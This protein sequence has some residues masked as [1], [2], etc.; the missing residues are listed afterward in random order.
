MAQALETDVSTLI[1]LSLAYLSAEWTDIPMVVAEWSL[2]EEHERLDFALE[3]PIREDRLRQL[4]TWR[5]KGLL[6]DEQR[7]EYE[8]L[9]ALVE[10]NRPMVRQLLAG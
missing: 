6:S 3:W 4:R 10:R 1:D 8:A 7:A 9:G 5:T 2:W